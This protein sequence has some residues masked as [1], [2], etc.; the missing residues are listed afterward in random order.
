MTG[1]GE[2]LPH[3]H[4]GGMMMAS[5]N[6]IRAALAVYYDTEIRPTLP[7]VKGRILGLAVG[8]ILAK[9]EAMLQKILPAAQMMGVV[10]EAG[11]V[12]ID[13]LAVE[14]KK[15]LFGKDGV[16]EI[17]KALNPLNPADVDVFRFRPA[18]VDKLLDIIK[19]M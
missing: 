3:F 8:V 19:R 17:K 16:L 15:N 10:D 4:K 14:A 5:L 7:D 6:Q 11:N 9:P 12:D 1:A 13:L 18:D 2:T